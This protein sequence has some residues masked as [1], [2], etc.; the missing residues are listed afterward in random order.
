MIRNISP[1]L[2]PIGSKMKSKSAVSAGIALLFLATPHSARAQSAASKEMQ[3]AQFFVGT[4]S[5]A[6]TVGDFSGT[7]K[8]TIT[9]AL[10]N[11][12]LKQTYDFP[13]TSEGASPV[14]AEYYIGYDP[15]SGR[16]IRLGAMSDG[17][18]FAMV[19]KRNGNSWPWTYVLPGQ[20]GSAVYTEKSD[21][22]YTVD[23][24]SYQQNGKPVTEHH[25]CRKA[26]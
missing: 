7:Y 8:T 2:L 14:T 13:A 23:G 17:L 10:D 4:W 3:T 20:G 26:P 18:Y 12:W 1:P 21:S 19:A 6:H 11:R 16:W 24:P 9:N 25:T 22:L 5:C 15:R